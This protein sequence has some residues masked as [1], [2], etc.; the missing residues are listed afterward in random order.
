MYPCLH[1]ASR[2]AC[3]C[4]QTTD[5]TLQ[6]SW[7][8]LVMAIQAR[9]PPSVTCLQSCYML[10]RCPV[11]RDERSLIASVSRSLNHAVY[12]VGEIRCLIVIYTS[13]A[14][15]NMFPLMS[16]GLLKPLRIYPCG[17]FLDTSFRPYVLFPREPSG[18]TWS[19]A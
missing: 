8:T 1:I 13:P 18:V 17:N 4:R 15:L 10:T 19:L 7:F 2:D 3:F 11:S 6:T 16:S 12:M 5:A 9:W 14:S